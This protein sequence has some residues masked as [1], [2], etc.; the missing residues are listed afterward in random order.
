MLGAKNFTGGTLGCHA[1]MNGI[2][3]RPTAGGSI[4]YAYRDALTR[5]SIDLGKTPSH[6]DFSFVVILAAPF[7][8][9]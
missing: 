2:G 8:S 7:V 1:V 5:L 4:S 3:Q 9:G 6:R